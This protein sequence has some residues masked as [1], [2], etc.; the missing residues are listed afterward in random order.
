[1]AMQALPPAFRDAI[2][3]TRRMGYRYLWI[4]SLYILQD[5]YEDWEM[6][7]A[8]MQEY[9]QNAMLTI[10]IDD[11]PGDHCDFLNRA[12]DSNSSTITIPFQSTEITNLQV[13]QI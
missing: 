5:S 6:E 7:S 8:L 3:V 4:D 9:Y 10:A 13:N 12:R 1:M 11:S 2:K